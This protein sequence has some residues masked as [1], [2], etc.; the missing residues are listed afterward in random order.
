M[1]SLSTEQQK[2][3][4]EEL[5]SINEARA[6]LP[7]FTKYN[8]IDHIPTVACLDDNGMRRLA[9]LQGVVIEKHFTSHRKILGPAIVFVKKKWNQLLNRLILSVVGRQLEFNQ[10]MWHLAML[11]RM[12]DQRISKIE[13]IVQTQGSSK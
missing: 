5:A 7:N 3:V 13:E 4:L 12:Q 10:E 11:V 9:L 2:K 8:M 1:R 6:D